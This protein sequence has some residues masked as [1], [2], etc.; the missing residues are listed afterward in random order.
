M[1]IRNFLERYSQIESES[2]NSYPNYLLRAFTPITFHNL[3]F[4]TEIKSE[5]ELWK[6]I[7]T[8]HEGRYFNNMSLLNDGFTVDEFELFKEAVD[9]CIKFTNKI[10]RNKEQ[11]IIPINAL[12]RSFISY[13]AIKSYYKSLKKVPS[14]LEIGPGSGYLGLL[15]GISGWQYS[16]FDVTKSLIT[17]QNALWSFAGFKLR[18]AESEITYSDSDFLQIPW[19]VW[20]NKDNSLPS[21][22][23]VVANHVIQEMS[24]LALSF[25]IKRC[26]NLGAKHILAEGL[27]YDTYKNNLKI[28]NQN[29][30]LVHNVLTKSNY[31][32]VWVWKIKNSENK[33]SDFFDKSTLSSFKK[34]KKLL[35]THSVKCKFVNYLFL[36]VIK[37]RAGRAFKN[38]TKQVI[39]KSLIH[40]KI[41]IEIDA[42]N[43][44][45]RSKRVPFTTM[46]EDVM[47]WANHNNH[48]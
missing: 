28:I 43:N 44:Y 40:P 34:I 30:V 2:F 19:W 1:R 36:K 17:Y 35:I 10:T 20:C 5:A 15:C 46:D 13:R 12:T 23:I 7:D 25:T 24:P 31:Q 3:G 39:D 14:V 45:I 29:T 48:I 6:Y 26:K 37:F 8:Q 21:R 9:I 16:S 38:K 27:G 47:R 22:E 4:Q 42:I 32:K 41:T 18:F 11:G 33:N